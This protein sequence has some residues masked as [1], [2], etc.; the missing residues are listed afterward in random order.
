MILEI[1]ICWAQGKVRKIHLEL[2]LS[3]KRAKAKEEKGVA[4]EAV[5]ERRKEEHMKENKENEV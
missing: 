1:T 2:C 5:T 4:A 3:M